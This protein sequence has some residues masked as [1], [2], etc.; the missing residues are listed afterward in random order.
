[1]DS[2]VEPQPSQN[3]AFWR[4]ALTHGHKGV[5][6]VQWVFKHLPSSARCKHCYS[7][8]SGAASKALGL[9]GYRPSRKNPKMCAICIEWLPPGGAQ[10][11][12]SV[13]FGDVRGSTSL[14]ERMDASAFAALMNRFY[15]VATDILMAHDA[16]IDKMVGDQVMA[17]FIPGF[18]GPQYR[19]LAAQAA[20]ALVRAA[21]YGGVGE[22][23]LPLGVGVHSGPAFVGNIG[24]GEVLDFTALGDTVN[25]AARLEAEAAPG[26]VLLTE[27]VYQEV[28]REYPHLEQR[29]LT[30]RGKDEPLAVRVLLPGLLP[31]Q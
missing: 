24:S 18:C 27:T 6:L 29:L 26:E 28:A 3:E 7:P 20:T 25:T 5:R 9:F 23:W 1:M 30:L 19:R 15:R 17:L 31:G 13:L 16:V 10:V 22:P 8:Y 4:E 11:D 21:G 2:T 12:I 14:G